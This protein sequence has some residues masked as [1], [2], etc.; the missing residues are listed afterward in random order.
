MPTNQPL[1]YVLL[2]VLSLVLNI[3]V[4][5]IMSMY[6]PLISLQNQNQLFLNVHHDQ[7]INSLA[8]NHD[9]QLIMNVNNLMRQ[10]FHMHRNLLKIKKK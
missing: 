1:Y 2:I 3:L 6:D 10:L 7:L 4:Y 5:H 8:L 9:K